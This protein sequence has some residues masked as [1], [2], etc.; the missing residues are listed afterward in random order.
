LSAQQDQPADLSE[1]GFALAADA[2]LG[3]AVIHD[4]AFGKDHH[5][6]LATSVGLVHFDGVHWTRRASREGVP[7]SAVTAVEFDSRGYL[8][9]GTEQCLGWI[10]DG[11]FHRL[12]EIGSVSVR[13][14]VA[15]ARGGMWLCVEPGSSR[16]GNV[17]RRIDGPWQWIAS[18]PP[19]TDLVASG[20]RVFVVA[21]Q[22][23]GEVVDGRVDWLPPLPDMA[24]FSSR[25]TIA[26]E[27]AAEDKHTPGTIVVA[28]RSSLLSLVD[29]SWLQHP[30]HSAL[31]GGPVLRT[32]SGIALGA[33]ADGKRLW[34]LETLLRMPP[35]FPLA[36][37]SLLHGLIEAPDHALWG[38]G[39]GSIVRY[40]AHTGNHRQ[41][42]PVLYAT[43]AGLWCSDGQHV[44]RFADGKSRRQNQISKLLAQSHTGDI[45]AAT[46]TP[47]SLAF[48]PADGGAPSDSISVLPLQGRLRAV[49]DRRGSA[50]LLSDHDDQPHVAVIDPLGV[51]T[52]I[53]APGLRSLRLPDINVLVGARE[54][55]WICAPGADGDLRVMHVG[56]RGGSEEH[57]PERLTRA[58]MAS[59]EDGRIAVIGNSGVWV[60]PPD[61]EWSRIEDPVTS[62]AVWLGAVGNLLLIGCETS[63]R[64]RGW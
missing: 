47:G 27:T 1:V 20:D 17:A 31:Q 10:H 23:L 12:P 11:S 14:L 2:G 37:K 22:R 36:E 45:L 9:L 26:A 6:W 35:P 21:H 29:G 63:C 51:V 55:A 59:L 3:S 8:W 48:L 19:A 43:A 56:R 50:W 16:V 62:K 30:G 58:T 49:F 64:S 7:E 13:R 39:E 34:R 44:F 25:L 52:R 60:R 54:G 33:R 42:P 4:I 5:A 38:F 15:D 40:P 61:G 24:S 57:V 46:T 53:E 18:D 32:S 28:T 41:V